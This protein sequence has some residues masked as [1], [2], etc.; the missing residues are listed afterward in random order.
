MRYICTWNELTSKAFKFVQSFIHCVIDQSGTQTPRPL[1]T[2]LHGQ[3][4]NE[5]LH[6][7]F[8]YMDTLDTNLM[9][10]MIIRD[11]LTG[12]T[13][14]CPSASGDSN[15][16]TQAVSKC[17]SA[18]GIMLWMLTNRAVH[19][20]T[21][22]MIRPTEEAHIRHY[23]NPHSS[24]GSMNPWSEHVELDCVHVAPCYPNCN[25]HSTSASNH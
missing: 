5:E 21:S 9:Y 19:I 14:L 20:M 25:Y 24:R 15:T 12:Y 22:L 1:E 7:D 4:R 8:L 6:V 11:D 18:L 16:A 17:I 2:S 3:C 10:I 23:L 13:C